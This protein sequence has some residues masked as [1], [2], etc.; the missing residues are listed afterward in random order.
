MYYIARLKMSPGDDI[1]IVMGAFDSASS[2]SNL[3]TVSDAIVSVMLP[4]TNTIR[5]RKAFLQ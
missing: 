4:N 2:V 1:I 5:E 3:R